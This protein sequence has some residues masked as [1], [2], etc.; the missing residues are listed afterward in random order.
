[1]ARSSSFSRP[2]E[3]TRSRSSGRQPRRLVRHAD[4]DSQQEIGR[5]TIQSRHRDESSEIDQGDGLECRASAHHARRPWNR[6][7]VVRIP[8]PTCGSARPELVARR[9]AAVGEPHS[10]DRNLATLDAHYVARQCAAGT[11]AR[12][13]PTPATVRREAEPVAK[14][15]SDRG[16]KTRRKRYQPC[17]TA[18]R[19]VR[20]IMT[21]ARHSDASESFGKMGAKRSSRGTV[22]RILYLALRP[23]LL[24]H[25]PLRGR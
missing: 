14:V 20:A 22:T 15:V 18:T 23:K 16:W 10:I 9:R 1:M 13:S 21:R 12:L 24:P 2:S 7:E 6:S 5:L 17:G 8:T 19:K 3:A 11:R 4:Q 25:S